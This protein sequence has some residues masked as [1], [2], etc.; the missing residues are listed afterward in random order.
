MPRQRVDLL[1]LWSKETVTVEGEGNPEDLGVIED[2]GVA[3]R[4]GGIVAVA[5]SQL[6]ERK[7]EA[8]QVMDVSGETILPGFV[9]PHNHLVFG[10]SREDEFQ[11]HLR[12]VPYMELLRKGG[13]ILETVNKTR[14]TSFH[15]LVRVAG[16][17]LDAAL[18]LGTTTIEVKSG[19]GLRL[20]D[21]LKSLEV[22]KGLK[23]SHPCNLVPTFLG[24]HAVP[25]ECPQPEKYARLVVEDMLPE[26]A[27]RRLARFCD[28]FCER[29]AFDEKSSLTILRAASRLGLKCKVH[30]D[31]F[32]HSGGVRVANKVHATS[33]DHLIH[34]PTPELSEMAGAGVT[35]V[36]LPASSQSLLM[37]RHANAREMLAMG[38]PVA[39][40]T[41]FSPANW[42]LG[43][44]TV[45]AIAARQL[46]M[47]V[48][49]IIRGITINAARALG[50]E[51]S[52]G[53]LRAGKR[54]DLVVL[55]APSHKWVGYAYEDLVDKVL[56]GGRLVVSGGRRVH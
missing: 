1:V 25:R 30:A 43:Q 44:I 36:L 19:Y 56:I 15:D 3:V 35:P 7:F 34:T 51:N 14:Q 9:D 28:V 20:H 11:Q 46:R 42:V 5:S 10:G 50:M 47:R 31:E 24:A 40:G 37:E 54:G 23:K 33:A 29:G 2:G 16:E 49:H 27:R 17:R 4:K 39:L 38:L 12:G 8:R 55:N 45:A 6:L 26:V 32:G 48:E 18:Q 53:S 13:G 41:D 21:E 52:V 22:A